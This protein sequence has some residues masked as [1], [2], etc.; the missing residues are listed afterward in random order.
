MLGMAMQGIFVC[1]FI[2]LEYIPKNKPNSTLAFFLLAVFFKLGNGI[3]M[4]LYL[5]PIYSYLPIFYPDKINTI[6]TILNFMIASS[7]SL[8]PLLG[9]L[10]Y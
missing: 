5:T 2:T 8:G 9:G 4:G 1:L 10:L 7:F 3:G 6:M